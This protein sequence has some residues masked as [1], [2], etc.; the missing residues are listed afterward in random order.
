MSDP[1][2]SVICIFHDNA[3]FLAEAIDSVLAQDYADFELLLC[4]DGASDGSSEIARGH[5][6][7][8]PDRIRY[9]EHPGHANRGMSAT[10]NLG[11]AQAR[12]EFVAVIDGDDR[13]WPGKLS[14]QVAILDAHPEV[15]MVSGAYRY[16]RSWNGAGRD[17]IY[18]PGVGRKTIAHP[19]ETSIRL[20]PLGRGLNPTAPMVRRALVERVG[21][22]VDSFTGLFED[23]V[24]LAKVYL[25]APVYFSEE[26]WLDYRQHPDSCTARFGR[27]D[28][29][30]MRRQF[31]HW[32]EGYIADRP[33]PDKPAL[34]RAI[35]RAHWELDHPRVNGFLN[36]LRWRKLEVG[37]WLGITPS[38]PYDGNS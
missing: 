11:L 34:E 1:R 6:E 32:L 30:A 18:V 9:L 31:L 24:F 13:W 4:D 33:L 15:G 12:G 10:R 28:W 26:L 29:A 3:P 2:V 37:R 5:A 17:W 23:Q 8:H 27:R 19:P 7:R 20:Y 21:G 22:Y 38:R 25:E 35:R 36:W 14:G 16:W